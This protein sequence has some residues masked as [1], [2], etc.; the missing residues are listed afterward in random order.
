M[1]QGASKQFIVIGAGISGLVAARALVDA[2]H[3][4]R[5]IEQA[6][7]VGGKIGVVRRDGFLLERGPNSFLGSARALWPWIDSLGLDNELLAAQ[8]PGDRWVYR[9]GTLRRLPRGPLSALGGNWLD[10]GDRIRVARELFV[11]ADARD[12]ETLYDFVARRCGAGFADGLIA[13]FTSGVYAGD[14]RQ[15]GARDAFPRMWRLEAEGGG[16]IRGAVALARA[17]KAE[18]GGTPARKGLWNFRDGLVTLPLALAASLSASPLGSVETSATVR[19]LRR[20]GERV[21]V[22]IDGA[23]GSRVERADAA[24]VALPPAP[25]AALLQPW[26]A[27]AAAALAAT[28]MAPIAVVHLGGPDPNASAP[29]GFG[30]LVARGEGVEALGVLVPSSL[31]A[32]RAPDGHALYAV[33]LGGVTDPSLVERD[34]DALIDLAIRGRRTVFGAAVDQA[35]TMAH[36]TRWQAAIPQYIVG[37]RNRVAHA[38]SLLEAESAPILLAGA[39][40]DGISIDDAAA[41]GQSQAAALL[42]RWGRS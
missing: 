9:G 26:A 21:V 36:V 42:A 13:P 6:E 16:L 29:Q 37:H 25:M 35:P 12:D 15:L 28:P 7:T 32:G 33:F 19:S 40:C 20:D 39:G 11:P 18:R 30:A 14:P 2:G 41:S 22:E 34:D 38:R 31:F 24:I 10:W 23:A 8:G 27:E 5:V 4:V 1:R 3:Q 17:R